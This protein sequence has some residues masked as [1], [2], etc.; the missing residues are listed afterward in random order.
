MFLSVMRPI[1][2][3]RINQDQTKKSDLIVPPQRASQRERHLSTTIQKTYLI[4]NQYPLVPFVPFRVHTQDTKQ[5][6]QK[7]RS[8]RCACPLWAGSWRKKKG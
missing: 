6:E 1:V 8:L 2:I 7:N 4:Y 3:D 5:K